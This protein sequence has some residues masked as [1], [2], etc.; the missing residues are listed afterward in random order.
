MTPALHAKDVGELQKA[1][2]DAAGKASVLWTSF[3][4][5]E[6]YLLIAFGSVTH[7]DLFLESAIKLPLLNVDL[8]LVGF[9]IVAPTIL[10]ILHFY[11]FLQL[12][13]LAAKSRDY[14]TLLRAEA[15]VASDRQ[16]LRQRLDSFFML[17]FLAGPSQQRAGF[18]GFWL[19]VIAWITLVGT[20]VLILLQGQ[21]TFLPFHKGSI[22]WLQR[23]I[24]AVDLVIIWFYW[25]N[26]RAADGSF[27]PF[28]KNRVWVIFGAMISFCVA[29]FSVGVATVP[30]ELTDRYF[31]S[32]RIVPTTWGPRWS[33]EA[34]WT[35]LNKL[36]FAGAPDEVSGRPGSFF[37]NRLVL[38]DQSFVDVEKIDRIAV[39]ISLRGRDLRKGVFNGSDLRKADFTAA[40][41]DGA[42]LQR[43]KLQNA[44]FG[45]TTF[46]RDCTSLPD[47]NLSSAQLQGSNLN[48]ANLQRAD[49]RWAGL[50]DSNVTGANLQ[51]AA[52][53]FA[54]LQGANL[55]GA[56]LKGADISM[57]NLKGADLR[58]AQLGG[59]ELRMAQLQG[60]NLTDA[61]FSGANLQKANLQVAVL[62]R[63]LL[64]GADLR[65][66]ELQG[67]AIIDTH[68]EAA[69]L[70]DAHL[71]AA[72]LYHA[73]LQGADLWRADFQ[74]TLLINASVWRAW[75]APNVTLA[76]L[77][78]IDFVTPLNTFR[79]SLA[80]PSSPVHIRLSFSNWRTD[81][82]KHLPAKSRGLVG[83]RL[84]VLDPDFREE[85]LP[86]HI[87][88]AWPFPEAWL[89]NG[90]RPEYPVGNFLAP[91]FWPKAMSASPENKHQSTI[92]PLLLELACAAE[93][94]PYTARG[95]VAQGAH[96]ITRLG[97]DL[98]ELIIRLKNLTEK[99]H[100]AKS[101][102][103]ACAGV[104]GFSEKDWDALDRVI[105]RLSKLGH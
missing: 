73:Q 100:R 13:A 57:A 71:Q 54:Q 11:V 32:A 2:N 49:L 59:A 47:A 31:P 64:Q 15:R 27:V 103:A 98:S 62:D 33:T 48:Q 89:S 74:S 65:G 16:Y 61:D 75:G 36:L 38:I 8:P 14:D 105:A 45:C 39:A 76:E 22:T 1:L 23:I 78:R 85:N 19:R 93:S 91:A 26:I 97:F 77:R 86:K 41:L 101:E 12:F 67:A 50:Q 102:L 29:I 80:D 56:N 6:L 40:Q 7:R 94:A 52:L 63:T 3:V 82:V 21:T 87:P 79:S 42:S 92:P 96:I 58:R 99:L 24:I 53:G 81:I 20:P 55:T 95:L 30:G 37:A 28:I 104:K 35:S 43:T 25:N 34:H 69:N 9:F 68:M 84:A 51:G 83:K 17:Q 70:Q 4:T 5:L 72:A 10:V 60:G 44:N 18:N 90:D 88:E 46:S 66:A